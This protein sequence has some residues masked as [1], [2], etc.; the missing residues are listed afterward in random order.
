MGFFVS[1][2]SIAMNLGAVEI[3]KLTVGQTDVVLKKLFLLRLFVTSA[4]LA[5]LLVYLMCSAVTAQH[6]KTIQFLADEYKYDKALIFVA[7]QKWQ[8]QTFEYKFQ[9]ALFGAL[10]VLVFCL[11]GVLPIGTFVLSII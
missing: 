2:F 6:F 4:S 7:F 8:Q 10:A 1:L 11:F 3:T 9:R 5:T